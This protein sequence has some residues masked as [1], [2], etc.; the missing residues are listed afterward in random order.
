[1][2]H[3]IIGTAGHV[4]HGKT[5]L[6]KA[7]TGIECDTHKQEKQRGITINLGFAHLDLPSGDTLGIVDVPGHRDFVHTMVGGAAGIDVA[8]LVVAADG[9]VMPQTREHLQIMDVLGIRG[10]LVALTRIDLAAPDL[11]D[12]AEEEIR[13][14]IEG[15]FLEGCPIVRVSSVTGEGIE[16]LRIAIAATAIGQESRNTEG[17][18]RLFVD[19]VFSVS[20]F[21][22][23]AAG[24]VM[25]GK[26]GVGEN[27]F[28]LPGA[29]KPLRVRRLERYGCETEQ[30]VA[31]DRAAMNLIGLDRSDFEQGNVISDRVLRDTTKLDARLRFFRHGRRFKIW[32]RVVFHLGTYEQQA[33]VHLIDRDELSGDET[34]LVQIHLDA[35]CVARQGDRFVVRSTSSDLTLGGGTVIDPAP[36]HHRRRPAELIESLARLAEGELAELIAA[37]L[38]KHRCTLSAE[39]LAEVLNV[40]AEEI[41]RALA[42]SPGEDVVCYPSEGQSHFIDR[43]VAE[44]LGAGALAAIADFHRKNPLSEKGRSAKELIGLLGIS[45][46]SAA[47]TVRLLLADLQSAGKLKEVAHTWA[48]A[49]HAVRPGPG[50]QRQIEFVSG[51]V[52][53]CGMNVPRAADLA[54]EAS[55]AG[56]DQ[57]TLD[58]ILRHLAERK[59]VVFA[60]GL[61]IDGSLVASC[62]EKLLRTLAD[63]D[64]GIGEQGITVA[65]FRDLIAGNRKV[66]LALLS[67]FDAEGVTRRTGDRRVLTSSG[68]SVTKL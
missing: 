56:I 46:D 26:V 51:H 5:A 60:D 39:Q 63:D 35:P 42:K 13:E 6:V 57:P 7:L 4:D 11:A 20:G 28:L 61:Y 36:L 10:G 21:G 32:S 68:R 45:G 55:R 64:R 25:S 9:G 17:I 31:G 43:S 27:V 54:S 29:K 30:V 47:V 41:V 23:V 44:R 34:A 48:L 38:K 58:Q 3:L 62:R 67:I 1:M 19:R 33:R 8:L 40:S 22:T 18:F 52:R 59:E 12:L 16:D 65:E 14:L 49:D 15:S 24:S 50:L 53:E 66:C 2:K 37:E